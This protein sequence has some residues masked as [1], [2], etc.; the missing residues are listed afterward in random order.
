MVQDML[1]S[2][3]LHTRNRSRPAE[4]PNRPDTLLHS[5]IKMSIQPARAWTDNCW[6][7][8]TALAVYLVAACIYHFNPSG[9][10]SIMEIMHFPAILDQELQT[11]DDRL[12]YIYKKCMPISHLDKPTHNPWTWT[13]DTVLLWI[14]LLLVSEHCALVGRKMLE[15]VKTES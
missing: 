6:S 11:F 1:Q 15:A 2:V 4:L 9:Y 7:K 10:F 14:M 13:A 3:W 5:L 8:Q 12:S